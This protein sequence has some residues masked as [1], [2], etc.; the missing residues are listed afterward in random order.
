VLNKA[1][2]IGHLGGD[3]DM[4][5]TADGSPIVNFSVATS[6]KRNGQEFTEWHKV[7]AFGKL[8][9]ICA[10]ILQ[11]GTLVYIEGR[12]H[13]RSWETKEGEK[14]T[15]TEIVAT[16]LKGLAK[17]KPRDGGNGDTRSNNEDDVPF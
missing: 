5:Y 14:K 3:P 16:N 4:R 8:A 17:L 7:V 12:I 11:K 2:I 9:E 1:E 13:S 6:Q 10:M 15:S